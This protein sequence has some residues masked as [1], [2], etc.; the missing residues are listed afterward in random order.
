MKIIIRSLSCIALLLL[1]SAL[2]GNTNAQETK[3]I[4]FAK[5]KSSATLT[6]T[7]KANNQIYYEVGVRKGQKLTVTFKSNAGNNAGITVFAPNPDGEEKLLWGADGAG[8]NTYEFELEYNGDY[9]IQVGSTR[10]C[11]YTL[12]VSIR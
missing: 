5:G 10:A 6:G 2:P 8:N 4:Q 9:G 1:F 3:R 12:T 7:L 11:N